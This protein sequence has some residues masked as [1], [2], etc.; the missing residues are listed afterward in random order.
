MHRP[1][2]WRIAMGAALV[3]SSLSGSL[4]LADAFVGRFETA[5]Q[6]KLG[7]NIPR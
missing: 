1:S 4:A 5:K 6:E 7:G 3:L 2:N